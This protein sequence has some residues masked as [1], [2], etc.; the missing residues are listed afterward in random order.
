MALTD[1]LIFSYEMNSATGVT[2]DAHSTNTLTNNNSVTT[3][4]G[5]IAEAADF[6]GTNQYLSIASNANIVA[7]DF[8]MTF[9]AWFY[10]DSASGTRPVFWKTSSFAPYA[11]YYDNSGGADKLVFTA[12]FN[13]NVEVTSFSPSTGTWYQ[14]I[15]KYDSVNNKNIIKVNNGTAVENAHGAFPNTDDG[16]E[17]R[18]GRSSGTDYLDG[19]VDMFRMWKRLTS[20]AEDTQLY[21]GGAGLAYADFA[22]GGS[23]LPLVAADMGNIR[24]V[25]GMRG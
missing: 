2:A 10:L 25:G 23:I 3:A 6:D 12:Y 11:L 15:C 21:N 18:V 5:V 9:E 22:G 14:A 16:G 7:G 13:N 19:R 17:L 4:A 1:D 24:D 8:D 20:D